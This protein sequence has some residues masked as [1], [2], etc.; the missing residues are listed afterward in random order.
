MNYDEPI[1]GTKPNPHFRGH[2]DTAFNAQRAMPLD[3][4][5]P[6]YRPL[7]QTQTCLPY[8][9]NKHDAPPR[10]PTMEARKPK[11]GRGLCH[12]PNLV[13]ILKGVRCKARS[14]GAISTRL[15]SRSRR[16]TS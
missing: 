6:E 1:P 2:D 13:Q 4:Q 12:R 16:V 7:G 8:D 14:R 15:Q 11:F 3:P 5:A 9:R 10:M